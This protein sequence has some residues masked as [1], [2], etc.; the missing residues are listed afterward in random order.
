[1]QAIIS[2]KKSDNTILTTTQEINFDVLE[3]PYG[4]TSFGF[5]GSSMST[6]EN[7]NIFW[8]F[9]EEL[10]IQNNLTN[11]DYLSLLN[12]KIGEDHY[13]L[14]ESTNVVTEV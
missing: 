3:L 7:L 8:T 4:C 9:I 14:L 2:I 6:E 5:N 12:I 11:D 10:L 1:M 13:G